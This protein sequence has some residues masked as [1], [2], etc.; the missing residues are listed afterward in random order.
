MSLVRLAT[1]TGFCPGEPAATPT[2]G[3]VDRALTGGG[4]RQLHLRRG[5]VHRAH[6]DGRDRRRGIG[7][8]QPDGDGDTRGG[9]EDDG[10]G[11]ED[12]HPS[13]PALALALAPA[14]PAGGRRLFGQ[15]L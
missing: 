14:R 15:R 5:H 4:P 12:E 8:A 3:T 10:D 9:D 2:E 13:P 7:R 1:G 11:H 6:Q